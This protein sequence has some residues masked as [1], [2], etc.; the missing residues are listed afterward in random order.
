[1]D[2]LVVDSTGRGHALCDLFVRTDPTVTVYYGPGCDLVDHP[3]I[4]CVPSIRLADPETVLA[5]LR[6]H[7]VEFTFVSYIDAL[8]GGLVDVLR[9]AGHAVIGPTAAA[10]RL[11]AS[12]A[13][14]KEFCVRHGIPVPEHAVCPDPAAARAYVRSRR[15]PCV[16]KTD[17]LTPDG[18]G[19]IVCATTAEALAAVDALA[20]AGAAPIV[21]EERLTGPE[22]SVFA[23]LDGRAAMPF[24]SAMDYKR[25][26]AGNAGKNCDGMGS[27]SPHPADD[28]ALRAE[29]AATLVAPLVRGLRAEGLAYTGFVYL[30][31]VLT[32]RGPVVIEINAR[33]GDSEAEV[34][35][36][37]VR[38]NFTDLCRATLAGT[39]PDRPVHHDHRSR[40]SVA[41][42]QGGVPDAAGRPVPGWPFGEFRTGQP[43][44]GLTGTEPDTTVYYANI[45][46]AA[47]GR[48]VTS[49]G[50]VL[51]VVGVGDDPDQARR[52]AY[53]RAA[54]I[55]FP[56]V[57]YRGDIGVQPGGPV[58]TES[59]SQ[60]PAPAAESEVRSYCRSF[61]AVFAS[62]S[63]DHLVASDGTRYLDFLSGAGTLNY[64]HNPAFIKR[65]LID[66]LVADGITHG[67]DLHTT[68]KQEFLTALHTHVLGPRNLEYR[69]QFCG[70]TGTNAVEAALKLARLVTGRMNVVAFGGAFH[71]VSTGALAVT[72]GA[73]YRKGLHPTL[74]A[75]THVPFP[76]SPL[77]SF[78]SL[79]LLEHLVADPSSGVE[80]PAAVIMETVQAEGGVFC[81]PPEFLTG[82][83][84]WCDRHQVLLIIDDVQA[85]CGRTG[86]F[87]SFERA[88]V[89]PDVVALSK[90]I[91][92]YGLPM[93]L[94]LIKPEH[95]VWQP[96]QHSGTFRGN[97]LAFVGATAALREYW[98]GERG[99][100]FTAEITDKGALV[101]DRLACVVAEYGLRLRGAGLLW[102]LDLTDT[103]LSAAK[104]S[105]QCFDLG[106][107]VEA[108]GRGGQV[109]K[110][111]P[112]LTID[113][114]SLADGL[115]LLV[116]AVRE[117][118]AE[119]ARTAVGCG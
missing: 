32:A 28:P 84:A 13:R 89:V 72:G 86:T 21:V 52:A 78:D 107:V 46:R 53:R 57:R 82:V 24:P 83:R 16:V 1:M 105:S 8:A 66:Y 34:V 50:R 106:L 102:G 118:A 100:R 43:V 62:A 31:A 49:G 56:G 73:S 114:Q 91:S 9:A 30:G 7:P 80:K 92:G 60:E 116:A 19:S 11:E 110:I 97:Q 79:D 69:V 109:L 10:A 67:L 88:G 94:V 95:D 119:G 40:C 39:L 71:G 3:R 115:D 37:G 54:R 25:T 87:F 112:P 59:T 55:T 26:L 113:R 41:L 18:D 77:G 74:P 33:F 117:V 90:S 17:G 12:K 5:F 98:A 6:D 20:A 68:A 45:R 104:V 4:R 103:G 108:C 99:T 14:G 85:G 47:D 64:G 48:P 63:G 29:L 101:A 58:H 65:A 51:H 61:P 15:Y 42:V 81:A 23:L 96:G 44:D 38:E 93:A 75:T 70:P 36:P 27:I 22:I 76:V 35:L 111:L 2:V